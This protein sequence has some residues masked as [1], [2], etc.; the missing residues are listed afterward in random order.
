MAL[1]DSFSDTLL[2]PNKYESD[3]ENVVPN[4]DEQ[5]GDIGTNLNVQRKEKLETIG[6]LI[7]HSLILLLTYETGN[8]QPL[9]SKMWDRN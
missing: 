7:S 5:I 9:P 8:F 1:D 2:S 3:Q 6:K 4:S